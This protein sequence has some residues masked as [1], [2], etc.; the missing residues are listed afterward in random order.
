[1][2]PKSILMGGSEMKANRTRLDYQPPTPTRSRTSQHIFP[3]PSGKGASFDNGITL[4]DQ[5]LPKKEQSMQEQ[6]TKSAVSFLPEKHK[7]IRPGVPKKQIPWQPTLLIDHET[8]T[9]TRHS[10]TAYFSTLQ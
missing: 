7:R 1:M 5:A 8:G 10:Q 4:P 9:M 6:V 2:T 3:L